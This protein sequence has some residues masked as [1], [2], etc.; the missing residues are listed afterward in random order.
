MQLKNPDDRWGTVS[1]S[2]HWLVVVLIVVMAYLGLTMTDLP[3]TPY[4][5][6]IYAL[7]KSVGLSILALVALRLLWRWYA[8]APR[9]LPGP[10]WQRRMATLT[11]AG[12]YL[13][14][15]AV[16][17][18]GWVMNS[19]AGFPLPWFGLVHLP[20]L[21]AHDEA[22]HELS[23]DWHEWLFWALVVLSL[24]HAAA[25]FW[26]HLFQGDATL[27]RMLPRRWLRVPASE[28]SP[29]A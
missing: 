7:H 4:K 1:Q 8:G 12:L 9:E 20:P 10:H 6:R 3:N 11:H 23:E 22:L 2:L 13:L 26:H 24:A 18:S 14:L 5:I 27:A 19:A 29:D 17:I 21:V 15:F 28:E 16:P 25:A